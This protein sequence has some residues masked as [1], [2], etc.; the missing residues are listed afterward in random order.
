MLK[1]WSGVLCAV[2]TLVALA[3]GAALAGTCSDCDPS[4]L[5]DGLPSPDTWDPPSFGGGTQEDYE[6]IECLEEIFHDL[7][8]TLQECLDSPDCEAD[9][10]AGYTCATTCEECVL[11]CVGV[12]CP[13]QG[14]VIDAFVDLL[15]E[16][17]DLDPPGAPSGWP[18]DTVCSHLTDG[19]HGQEVVDG[20]Y[21]YWEEKI[22]KIGMLD[23][24][25]W[26]DGVQLTPE[27][28]WAIMVGAGFH[29]TNDPNGDGF[30]NSDCELFGPITEDGG[31]NPGP[32]LPLGFPDNGTPADNKTYMVWDRDGD[33][34][35]GPTDLGMIITHADICDGP[36]T[37]NEKFD[38]L[39]E[40]LENLPGSLEKTYCAD[41]PAAAEQALGYAPSSSQ[42]GQLQEAGCGTTDHEMVSAATATPAPQT[43]GGYQPDLIE[44][45]DSVTVPTNTLEN[46]DPCTTIPIYTGRKPKRPIRPVDLA[47]G[48]KVESAVDLVVRLPGNDFK[49]V[50]SYRSSSD[51]SGPRMVGYNW[52]LNI[53]HALTVDSSGEDDV[54]RL[55]NG[56]AYYE[57]TYNATETRWEAGGATAQYMEKATRDIGGTAYPMWRLVEPGHWSMDFYRE[58][59]TGEGGGITD[60]DAEL[61]GLQ[62]ARE[63]VYGVG[64]EFDYFII[65]APTTDVARPSSMTFYRE[66]GTDIAELRFGWHVHADG[67]LREELNGMLATIEVIRYDRDDSNEEVVTQRVEY[68]YKFT[69]TTSGDVP[70]DNIEKTI[71]TPGDLVQVTRK[72]LVDEAESGFIAWRQQHTQYRYHTSGADTDGDGYFEVGQDHALKMVINPEQVE[73]L[74]QE[75]LD[76]LGANIPEQ[77]FFVEVADTVIEDFAIEQY[78]DAVAYLMTLGDADVVVTGGSTPIDAAAKIVV[79]YDESNDTNPYKVRVQVLKEACGCGGGGGESIERTYKYVTYTESGGHSFSTQ[80]EERLLDSGS[81]TYLWRTLCYDFYDDGG[82]QV[83][84]LVNEAVVVDHAHPSGGTADLGW[85]Y[86]Y[87]YDSVGNTKLIATPS[88]VSSYTMAGASAPTIGFNT[89][90]GLVIYQDFN[91]DNRLAAVGV[92]EGYTALSS[93]S[94]PNGDVVEYISKITYEGSGKEHLVDTV[95]RYRER[96]VDPSSLPTSGDDIEITRFDYGLYTDG[97]IAWIK[98]EVEQETEDE[99]GPGANSTDQYYDSYVLYDANGD[100]E[101]SVDATGALIERVFDGDHGGVTS[102]TANA[103]DTNLPTSPFEGLTIPAAWGRDADGGSL[104]TTYDHDFLG[105]VVEITS[106]GESERSIVR[107]MRSLPE[108]NSAPYYVETLLPHIIDD[109][110]TPPEADG[111]IV[112]VWFTAGDTPVRASEYLVDDGVTLGDEVARSYLNQTI[113]GFVS[114]SITHH[115]VSADAAYTTTF[116][117]DRLGRLERVLDDDSRVTLYTYDEPGRISKVEV[118]IDNGASDDVVTV[119]EYVYDD[120]GT[121]NENLTE[122][123]H[124]ADGSTT[125][126]T[127]LHYDYRDRL[128]VA[129]NPVEPHVLVE[130][131]NLDRPIRETLFKNIGG[132]PPDELGDIATGDRG[133]IVETSYSQRGIP[134]RQG[135]AVDVTAGTLEFIEYHKVVDENGRAVG[136]IRPGAPAIK[137]TLD[138]LGRPEVV[139]ATD[140]ASDG[141]PG[142]DFFFEAV[143]D[144]TGIE[145]EVANDNVLEQREYDYSDY[146]D[147]GKAEIGKGRVKAVTTRMRAHDD[148]S[149]G[150]LDDSGITTEIASYLAYFYDGAD[151]L[152]HVVDYGT[153]TSGFNTGSSFTLSTSG[154]APSASANIHIY[155]TV[156]DDQGRVLEEIDP[157]DVVT[158]FFYD[159]LDRMIAAAENYTNAAVSGNGTSVWTV[160]GLDDTEPD[161]DKVTSFVYDAADNVVF[162]SAHQPDGTADEPQTTKYVYAYDNGSGFKSNSLLAKVHYPDPSSGSPSTA[163]AD[164]VEYE[165]NYLGEAIE[166]TDQ[167]GTT[168]QLNRDPLGRVT[169]DAVTT[170]GTGV[171]EWANMIG[172]EFDA[173]GRLVEVTAGDI[174]LGTSA[175][176]NANQLLYTYTA[177]DGLW[178]LD[179]FDQV[180]QWDNGTGGAASNQPTFASAEYAF[181]TKYLG[182]GAGV[183]NYVRMT[184]L[185]YPLP[186]GGS[187]D[188]RTVITPKYFDT[189][190]D[191]NDRI[192]RAIGFGWQVGDQT[193]SPVDH[194][195]A[196]DLLGL[197]LPVQ[198]VYDQPE[199]RL[200]RF[201][202]ADWDSGDPSDSTS[203]QYPGLDRFGRIERHTWGRD[204]GAT[205]WDADD[206]PAVADYSYR[207]NK[208]SSV[209]SRYDMR[210]GA[211]NSGRDESYLYDSIH[212]LQE[213]EL[214]EFDGTSFSQ[215][216]AGSTG[217]ELWTLDMLGNWSSYAV[218]SSDANSTYEASE[219]EDREHN[220]TNELT[221]WQDT[222]GLTYDDNGNLTEQ[223]LTATDK[224]IFTYDAWDRLVEVSYSRYGSGAWQTPVTRA[225]YTYYGLHQRATS[226]VDTDL[227]GADPDTHSHFYYDAGW[228]LLER[229]IDDDGAGSA[230]ASWASPGSFEHEST[231]QYVW[232]MRYIDE[233]VYY[234]ID[235]DNDEDFADDGEGHYAIT[236]RNFSVIGVEAGGVGSG[237]FERARY[238]AYGETF[239]MPFGDV[240]ADGDADTADTTAITAVI[241]NSLG[242]ASYQVE[243][244]IDLDGSIT[245]TDRNA[246]STATHGAGVLSGAGNIVGYAGYLYEEATG[247]YLARHRWYVPELG[248]WSNRD[249]IGYAGGD[250]NLYG[251]VGAHPMDATDPTGLKRVRDVILEP[252]HPGKNFYHRRKVTIHHY[253]QHGAWSNG[254]LEYRGTE[255][256]P[257]EYDLR[258]PEDVKRLELR[259]LQLEL[260]D[261]AQEEALKAIYELAIEYGTAGAMRMAGACAG[262]V[263]GADEAVEGAGAARRAA[264]APE[265][266]SRGMSDGA[267]RKS[268]DKRL[269]G[270]VGDGKDA[271]H[272]LPVEHRGRFEDLGIDMADP[273]YGEL[274]T[275]AFHKRVHGNLGSQLDLNQHWERWLRRNPNATLD[276]VL[277]ELDRV[278]RKFTPDACGCPGIR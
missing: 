275:P 118:G 18:S 269:G 80:I 131:D 108:R 96:E 260:R 223:L 217:S 222:L 28:T 38:I 150:P 26:D 159:D 110:A 33:H 254:G 228:R 256:D 105:R 200:S 277:K 178:L 255:R 232:G 201:L 182:E 187:G 177:G 173:F 63:N 9:C 210:E 109:Q 267:V 268:L 135:I 134:Y 271:H 57:F 42:M 165:Y 94:W 37:D 149:T 49:L 77:D 246:A 103:A 126:V 240:D 214:G 107:S 90:D 237:E 6:V 78:D 65:D 129:E 244:D 34:Q 68:D 141:D 127:E 213:R 93:G 92:K 1:T 87:G 83:P 112:R 128:V 24:T 21:D 111:P 97:G 241:G 52:N 196:Y 106:P 99:N 72:T 230:P 259:I 91:G 234:Q 137:V 278:K 180:P 172:Y 198:T 170:F 148:S 50:R 183:N 115:D 211:S 203:G 119:A 212:R 185:S 32:D 123:T 209:V 39:K 40:Y 247:M 266:P 136:M 204:S 250:S 272:W 221:E 41:F 155:E 199:L 242:G 71:G 219:T 36:L 14:E 102:V 194:D 274:L 138:G 171:D 224:R 31:G 60:P 3:V 64:C 89:S 7:D 162:R 10:P 186:G 23:P 188:Y 146:T 17:N 216:T 197:G 29:S 67:A 51:G 184:G 88:A 263:K 236:D 47:T 264:P 139:Y 252:V 117:Y 225:Q 273:K 54:V 163:T 56:H 166:L 104:T 229:R 2:W 79:E 154:A 144:A 116:E 191:V 169:L 114:S 270:V 145:A 45:N 190:G 202:D 130:Y 70:K 239:G 160:T 220:L 122:I 76:Q 195:V 189:A 61:I 231:H 140:G 121:G 75:A 81:F 22:K 249:P 35:I 73:Y 261:K 152:T 161:V 147:T 251:Y 215:S 245:T 25:G 11:V 48:D 248:R 243:A 158:R 276:D 82:T 125:R 43:E 142:D 133:R 53:F 143:Y 181:D 12:D 258:D 208:V 238:S 168:R 226:L 193:G 113:T 227:V 62:A 69:T 100:A 8:E 86:H 27:Q 205:P 132:T 98:T 233:L 164:T 257:Y 13:T 120:D 157:E 74:V 55:Y 253:K 20:F 95:T 167:N 175:T 235:A 66:D 174:N 101:W 58:K 46:L 151:R 262:L 19:T 84:Q 179:S 156:F 265:S 124:H 192:S 207:Y 206:N 218:D 176:T 4:D 59:D 30:P 153:N 85:V 15:D 44:S 5:L 16:Y